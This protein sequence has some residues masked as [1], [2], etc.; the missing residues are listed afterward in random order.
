MTEEQK[1]GIVSSI[2]SCESARL[3]A[4]MLN[5]MFLILQGA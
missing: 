2:F 3:E 4:Y 1:M 5:F